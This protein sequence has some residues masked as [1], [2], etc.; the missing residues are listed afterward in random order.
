MFCRV[1]P[2]EF[3]SSRFTV[4]FT[5]PSVNGYNNKS[6]THQRF[7]FIGI[8]GTPLNPL[9][10]SKALQKYTIIKLNK[11]TIRPISGKKYDSHPLPPF[12]CFL[13]LASTG[14]LTC[15]ILDSLLLRL[16][17]AVDLDILDQFGDIAKIGE[18]V[19]LLSF[20]SFSPQSIMPDTATLM[21]IIIAVN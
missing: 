2:P 4:I 16:I 12:L 3:S 1:C 19:S 15:F 21:F 18:P 17:L 5:I 10:E 6:L 13:D 14:F 7:F 8:L 9:V 20:Q 11:H